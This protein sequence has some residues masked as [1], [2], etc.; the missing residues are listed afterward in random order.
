MNLEEKRM[1]LELEMEKQRMEFEM[2]R[3]EADRQH[4]MNMWA[5][6]V[7]R[8]FSYGSHGSLNPNNL[9]VTNLTVKMTMIP[10]FNYF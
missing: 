8:G 9:Q 10:K 2:K 5:M 3:R 1:K 6:L 7:G 4:E